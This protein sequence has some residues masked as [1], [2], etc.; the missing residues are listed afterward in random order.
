MC[1]LGSRRWLDE[2]HKWWWDAEAFDRTEEHNLK[3]LGR[4]ATLGGDDESRPSEPT[5]DQPNEPYQE[6]S[7]HVVLDTEDI[8]VN[9]QHVL[10][11]L[12]YI[13]VTPSELNLL[14]CNPNHD[15][16]GFIDDKYIDDDEYSDQTEEDND[17][18]YHEY[19]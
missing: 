8:H 18:D 9:N 4:F 15:D 16:D 10:A 13:P 11:I 6:K 5:T 2:D 19:D 12:G 17:S 7:P 3:T 1:F 14:Q